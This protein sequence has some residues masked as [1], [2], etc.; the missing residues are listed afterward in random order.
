M[1]QRFRCDVF[2][3]SI[4]TRRL[5]YLLIVLTTVFVGACAERI[6]ISVEIISLPT[7][8][9][10][11]L[12]LA[13]GVHYTED[14]RSYRRTVDESPW[15]YDLSLGS[16]SVDLFDQ[17]LQSS[18][19]NVIS[20]P[21]NRLPS[22]QQPSPTL[23]L[24]PSLSVNV[25]GGHGVLAGYPEYTVQYYVNFYDINGTK[26]GGWAVSG[27]A[28][29]IQTAMRYAAA[30]LLSGFPDQKH[31]QAALERFQSRVHAENYAGQDSR[32]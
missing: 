1:A 31:V 24:E 17:V 30:K 8:V 7:P 25:K 20:V 12:P 14:F 2:G 6:P 32:K 3:A 21:N 9:V 26:L 29:E 28:S 18:F 13:V 23:I 4:G 22:D 19:D 27:R 16:G 10:E 11:K 5:V 15:I